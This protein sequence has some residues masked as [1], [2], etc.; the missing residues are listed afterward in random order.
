VKRMHWIGA[1]LTR[2]VLTLLAVTV[3]AVLGMA[4][5]ASAAS[6]TVNDTNDA[7]LADSSDTNCVS[8]D[9]GPNNCTLRAAVQAADNSGG[10]ST[11]TV[12]AGDYKLTIP[13]SCSEQFDG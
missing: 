4:G 11:I 7:P 10:S 6:Y 5:V 8:T 1:M 3:F 2:R 9:P 12:P 13:A